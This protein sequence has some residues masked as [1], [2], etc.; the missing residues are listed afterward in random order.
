MVHP[1][2]W[3]YGTVHFTADGRIEAPVDVSILI[4]A[5]NEAA[6]IGAAVRQAADAL[7][8]RQVIVIDGG[9]SDGTAAIASTHA[10]VLRS[11]RSRGAALNDAARIARGNVLLFLH[12][13]TH[14]PAGAGDEIRRVL[15]DRR[16]V[17]GAFRFSFDE[18]RAIARAIAAWVNLRSRM[19]NVFL[20]DQAL[21][22]RKDIFLRAGGFRDWD[23]MEDLEILHR[24]RKFGRLRMTRSSITTSARRHVRDGWLRTTGTVWMVTWLHFFGISHRTLAV[25]YR[26]RAGRR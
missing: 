16:V 19:F 25:L 21:F 1:E 12:A 15:H 11:T 8:G 13:D 9:S 14:L 6:V 24:L 22:V 2:P 20:G 17:G 26:R 5:L 18:R 23:L 3:D 10:T 4:P 7:P